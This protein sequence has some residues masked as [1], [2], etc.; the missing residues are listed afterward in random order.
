MKLILLFLM[1][2]LLSAC[3]ST[4]SRLT[5]IEVESEHIELVVDQSTPIRYTVFPEDYQDAN[6]M[7]DFDDAMLAFEDDIIT[8]LSLGQTTLDLVYNND[9]KASITITIYDATH[10]ITFDGVDIAPLEIAHNARLPHESTV[11]DID[12]GLFLGWYYD[13]ALTEPFTYQTRLKDSLTLYPHIV[14]ENL[15]Y[16]LESSIQEG[17]FKPTDSMQHT[18]I[19]ADP[20]NGFNFPYVIFIPSNRNEVENFGYKRYLMFEGYNTAYK[21]DPIEDIEAHAQTLTSSSYYGRI[22]QE[23]LFV[24]RIMPILPPFLFMNTDILDIDVE[25]L[26]SLSPKEAQEL[27]DSVDILTDTLFGYGYMMANLEAYLGN[28]YPVNLEPHNEDMFLFD[29]IS[30]ETLAEY[31]N[32]PH[33]YLAM[34]DDA[35]A[36]LNEAGWNL[37]EEIFLNGFSASGFFANRFATI[38]PDRVK[39]VFAGAPYYVVLPDESIDGNTLTYPLGTSDYEALF[40]HPFDKEAYLNTPK[41]Y[42]IGDRDPLDTIISSESANRDINGYNRAQATM[43]ID[44]FGDGAFFDRFDNM[45]DTYYDLGGNM[46]FLYARGIDHRM[47]SMHRRLVTNFFAINRN[48]EGCLFDFSTY[49][50][51][52][53]IIAPPSIH[54]HLDE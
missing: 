41:L 10:I 18:V 6:I 13:E 24:P 42:F 7:F 2:F 20:E 27:I 47:T 36:R 51:S 21:T 28:M 54:C 52:I 53:D 45:I 44:M 39:A 26:E 33:Q 16:N 32:L 35:Q 19:D 48:H 40:G 23:N 38:Y 15:N 46:T 25:T 29:L 3:E 43:M 31:K 30:E 1:I 34:I 11:P 17:P 50:S 8:A 5:H 12:E 22:F 49:E 14:D 4:Q 37:E 9:V